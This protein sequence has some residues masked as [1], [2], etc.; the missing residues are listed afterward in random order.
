MSRT[1]NFRYRIGRYWIEVTDTSVELSVF[2]MPEKIRDILISGISKNKYESYLHYRRMET[3][4]LY[5]KL[6][7]IE[8]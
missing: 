8:D 5:S 3:I 1:K 4:H 6:E 2:D 7:F